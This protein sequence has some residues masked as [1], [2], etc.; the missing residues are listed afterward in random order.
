MTEE[1][2][3]G[4]SPEIDAQQHA[5]HSG[6]APDLGAE[7]DALAAEAGGAPSVGAASGADD[8]PTAQVLEMVIG[9]AAQILAPNWALTE[10]EVKQLSEAYALVIDKYFPGMA[11]G[12]ELSAALVTMVVLAPRIGK[13]RKS[14]PEPEAEPQRQALRMVMPEKE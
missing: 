11:M 12:P 4:E 13:P 2:K 5:E 3:P 9:P 1:T 10:T 14:E 6:L 7:F 8:I